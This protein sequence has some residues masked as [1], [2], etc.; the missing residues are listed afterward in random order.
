MKP[1]SFLRL[2]ILVFLVCIA[3]LAIWDPLM[4][5]RHTRLVLMACA[6]VDARRALR[7]R[8]PA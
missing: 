1:P 5:W 8:G 4:I 7:R 3:G 6:N 2:R